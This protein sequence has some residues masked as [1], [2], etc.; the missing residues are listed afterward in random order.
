M[1]AGFLMTSIFEAGIA[2]RKMTHTPV[3]NNMHRL[4]YCN[5]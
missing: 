3:L 1:L 5:M 2:A 4:T